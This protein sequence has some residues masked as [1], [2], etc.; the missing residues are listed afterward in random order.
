MACASLLRPRL[1]GVPAR[2]PFPRASTKVAVHSRGPRFP[3]T[4]PA[5]QQ[6]RHTDDINLPPVRESRD[7][8]ARVRT[9]ARVRFEK[10][11]QYATNGSF[12]L[13]VAVRGRVHS[14]QS[15]L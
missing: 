2:R 6:G 4:P 7:P 10:G 12:S 15:A 5:S 3:N 14:D 8:H 13:R 1:F 11:G 9:R